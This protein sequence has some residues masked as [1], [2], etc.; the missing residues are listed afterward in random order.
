[1]SKKEGLRNLNQREAQ[2]GKQ[3]VETKTKKSQK[4]SDLGWRVGG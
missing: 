1:M 3:K 4:H 2:D